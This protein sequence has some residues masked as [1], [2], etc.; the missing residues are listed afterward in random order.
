[1]LRIITCRVTGTEHYDPDGCQLILANHPTLIDVVIL[2][3]L[4]PQVE[5]VIKGAVMQNPVLRLPARTA[6]YISN[7]DPAELLAACVQRL[8]SGSGLLLFPEGTRTVP[9]E[10]IRFKPG[11]A[12]IALRADAH[13]LPVVIDCQ[14]TFL[15]K[16]SRWYHVPSSKPHFEIRILPPV[17]TRDLVPQDI[18]AR[19]ARVMLNAALQQLF[20]SELE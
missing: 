1:M 19:R 18:G 16:R 13:I 2:V 14:P 8:E 17:H 5:C 6:N 12:E 7:F 11:A 3:S 20:E 9:G 4:F 10:S 15:A